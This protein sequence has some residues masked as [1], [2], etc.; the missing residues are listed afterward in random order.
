MRTRLL[1]FLALLSFPLAI[2]GAARADDITDL[3][4][5]YA[6]QAFATVTKG[7]GEGLITPGA[8]RWDP[9]YDDHFNACKGWGANAGNIAMNETL[10][11]ANDLAALEAR[12]KGQ[13]V[14][15]SAN[16]TF[17]GET[18]TLDSFCRGYAYT[19]GQQVA[20]KQSLSVSAKQAGKD[21]CGYPATARWDT[22]FQHH[23]DACK[24][25]GAN[26]GTN[27]ANETNG[28]TQ[29]I[30]ACEVAA[31][32]P[33]PAAATPAPATTTD[34]GNT[35]QG[36]GGGFQAGVITG[37]VD[38]YQEAGGNGNPIGFLKKGVKVQYQCQDDNWCEVQGKGW[39]WG[40]FVRAK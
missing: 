32:A 17:A 5:A 35:D 24:G 26:A 36:N 16:H 11:R 6:Q 12:A 31:S 20:A 22:D 25:W 33:A 14:P 21:V 15:F 9:S 23:L 28:R 34:Q 39:I 27:S 37:D 10:G 7:A 19:A 18:A 40:D 3:C 8:G 30:I 13:P 4:T 29:D 2:S 1:V 38:L